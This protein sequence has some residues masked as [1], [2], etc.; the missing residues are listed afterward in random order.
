[1]DLSKESL[2]WDGNKMKSWTGE[3]VLTLVKLEKKSN[4]RVKQYLVLA[5]IDLD[6]DS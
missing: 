3:G 5:E 4:T 2:K 6:F 1:M